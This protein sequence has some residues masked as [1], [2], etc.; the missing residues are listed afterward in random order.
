MWTFLFLSISV[1]LNLKRLLIIWPNVL[2]A[3][4][5]ALVQGHCPK[6]PASPPQGHGHGLVPS[7]CP[8]ICRL[9][10]SASHS[11]W[12]NAARNTIKTNLQESWY[13]TKDFRVAGEALV[14]QSPCPSCIAHTAACS[15]WTC[16]QSFLLNACPVHLPGKSLPGWSA[17]LCALQL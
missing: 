3:A 9:Q 7:L 5:P 1:L 15:P 10:H 11:V 16:R 8:R 2:S 14:S 17:F 4:F 6:V 12:E 13:F